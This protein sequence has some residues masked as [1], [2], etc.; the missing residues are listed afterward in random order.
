MAEAKDTLLRQLVTLQLVPR[1]PGGIATTTL[2]EKLAERG[3]YVNLRSLQRDLKDRLSLQ[4]PLVCDESEKPF[5]WS[6]SEDVYLSVPG[7]DTPTALT[8]CLAEDYLRTLL[9]S[10]IADLLSPQFT[11]ARQHLQGLNSNSLARWARSVRALPNGKSLIPAPVEGGIWQLVSEA[12]L[13][14][15][16]ILIDYLSRNKGKVGQYQLHPVGLVARHSVSYLIARVGEYDN[17]RHFALHRV[18][19]V[20]RLGVPACIAQ[21]FDIETYIRQ[22]AFSMGSAE[23]TLLVADIHPQLAWILGETPL[24]GH[25]TIRSLDGTDWCRLE[26]E[27]TMD[28][29][30]LWW[31]LGLGDRVRVLQPT[32]WVKEITRN[33]ASVLSAY[34]EA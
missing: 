31:L 13:G 11:A 27:V 3:F 25:Q 24:S 34:V 10:S 28:H 6:F 12:L 18:R 19:R 33:A 29:E 17:L 4:F 5:R 7:L 21:D 30:T 26:A 8:L 15:E 16:Q 32:E 14:K 9:P 20:I 2:Q 23:R 1:L 22:G